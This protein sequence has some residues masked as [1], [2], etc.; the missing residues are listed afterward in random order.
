MFQEVTSSR[1]R[2]RVHAPALP[3]TAGVCCAC[4]ESISLRFQSLLLSVW[5]SKEKDI[6]EKPQSVCCLH[7]MLSLLSKMKGEAWCCPAPRLRGL[8]W[9]WLSV[10]GRG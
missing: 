6:L 7:T 9:K 5:L 3:R 1:L 10:L 8:S 2:P 4:T